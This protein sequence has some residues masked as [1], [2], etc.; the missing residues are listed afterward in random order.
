VACVGR[1]SDYDDAIGKANDM[2][3][4]LAATG[5]SRGGHMPLFE[6]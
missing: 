5:V 4:G 6:L 2:P 1:F 3:C